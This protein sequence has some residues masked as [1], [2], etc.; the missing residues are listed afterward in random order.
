[1]LLEQE[2]EIQKKAAEFIRT[3]EME[4][5]ELQKKQRAAGWSQ[6]NIVY[7]HVNAN[8]TLQEKVLTSK[9]KWEQIIFRCN[10]LQ[11]VL[12]LLLPHRDMYGLYDVNGMKEELS[13]LLRLAEK[14]DEFEIAQ[15]LQIF[16]RDFPN[17]KS[18]KSSSL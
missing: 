15:I 2:I 4:L 6:R 10:V 1:M 12:K 3:L 5:E 18:S 11:G 17:I 16:L 13:S 9:N 7:D 8:Y 14:K